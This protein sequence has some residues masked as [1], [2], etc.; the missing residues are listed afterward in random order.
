[1]SPG[2]T[3]KGQGWG[4]GEN[5]YARASGRLPGGRDAG[6]GSWGSERGL[7]AEGG[8]GTPGRRTHMGKG[9]E[10]R[11]TWQVEVNELGLISRAVGTSHNLSQGRGG[12]R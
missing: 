5:S 4:E 8:E 1:M 6:R 10:E 7:V 9:L 3:A 12:G 2:L 11:T